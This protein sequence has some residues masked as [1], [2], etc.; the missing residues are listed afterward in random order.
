MDILA[1]R[2]IQLLIKSSDT[3]EEADRLIKNF[4]K[5]NLLE[6]KIRFLKSVFESPS[7]RYVTDET[8]YKMCL[9]SLIN[10]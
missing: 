2:R 6:D 9:Y 10:F 8:L 1:L 7:I 3:V 5:S 4:A